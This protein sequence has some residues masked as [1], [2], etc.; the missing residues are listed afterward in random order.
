MHP[1][2][3]LVDH[4]AEGGPRVRELRQQRLADHGGAHGLYA[5]GG[6]L[7]FVLVIC[8]YL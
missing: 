1:R 4:G 6:G 5:Y 3:G 8:F 2:A 7:S